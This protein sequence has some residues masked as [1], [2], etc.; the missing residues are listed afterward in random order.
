MK[1]SDFKMG[2]EFRNECGLL[3]RVTDIGT[4]TIVAIRIDSVKITRYDV[5]GIEKSY[6]IRGKE[7]EAAGWFKGPPY[8]VAEKVLDESDICTCDP[9][10]WSHEFK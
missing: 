10:N 4:R 9:I 3:F 5:Q 1:H 8:L 7:A 6:K 2:M